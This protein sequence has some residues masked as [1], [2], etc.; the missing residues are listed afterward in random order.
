MSSWNSAGSLSHECSQKIVHWRNARFDSKRRR[1]EVA[2]VGGQVAI[3]TSRPM[4]CE[5]E[6]A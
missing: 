4:G 6:A 1:I 5:H 3:E 2:E